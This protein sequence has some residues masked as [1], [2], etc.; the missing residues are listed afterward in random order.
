MFWKRFDIFLSYSHQDSALT[1]LLFEELKGFGYRVF[2]DKSSI[3]VGKAWKARI[4]REIRSSRVCIL[5]WS[6][7]AKASEYVTYEYSRAMGLGKPVLPWLLDGTELL[8]M[9]EI[10]AVTE[11][12]PKRACREFLPRLG[13]T[14]FIRRLIWSVAFLPVA[15]CAVA[16]Y[17]RTHQPWEFHGRVTD[18]VTGFPIAGVKVEAQD[19]KFAAF[20]TADGNYTLRLPS[21]QPKYIDLVFLKDGYRG[22]ASGQVHSDQPF[23]TDMVQL[24]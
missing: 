7:D 12:D 5:C 17:W 18:S 23:N 16:V 21:P 19:R 2:Y 8:K 14:M 9:F 6:K 4:D 15:L 24:K 11:R 22:E 20:T 3:P 1:D 10:Q 13:R